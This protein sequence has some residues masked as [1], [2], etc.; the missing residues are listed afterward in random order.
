[1]ENGPFMFHLL[2]MV[3]FY[4]LPEGTCSHE[5][6]TWSPTMVTTKKSPL[7]VEQPISIDPLG[8]VTGTLVP[9]RRIRQVSDDCFNT[10]SWSKFFHDLGVP[11]WLW[12]ASYIG[13]D[14]TNMNIMNWDIILTSKPKNDKNAG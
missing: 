6:V 4:S 3:I 10:K 8:L 9:Q 14:H 11:P 1:M 13:D 7:Q 12:K 5:L 2:K